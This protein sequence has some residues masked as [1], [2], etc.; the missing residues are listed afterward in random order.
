MQEPQTAAE[1]IARA[2]ALR[3]K[4]FPQQRVPRATICPLPPPRRVWAEPKAPRLAAKPAPF[5]PSILPGN[6]RP[7]VIVQDCMRRWGLTEAELRGPSRRLHIILCRREAMYLMAAY[8]DLS[9]NAIAGIM[10]LDHTSVR[11]AVIKADATLGT[12]IHDRRS[13]VR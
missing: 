7:A 10:G 13:T 4:F 5:D 1:V 6:C 11:N 12:N 3:A 8:T 9:Y 2:R